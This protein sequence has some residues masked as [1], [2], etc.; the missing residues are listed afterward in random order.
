MT[1]T[2]NTLPRIDPRDRRTAA[3]RAPQ[4]PV[5]VWVRRADN[6]GEGLRVHTMVGTGG[7]D[8]DALYAAA[9]YLGIPAEQI[10]VVAVQGGHH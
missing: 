9:R 4:I 7:W 6:S 1:E 5:T 10:T 3:Q 2:T 8:S